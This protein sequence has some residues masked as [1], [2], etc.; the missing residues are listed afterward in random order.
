M[1][2]KSAP[3]L[4]MK[5]FEVEVHPAP[6]ELLVRSSPKSTTATPIAGIPTTIQRSKMWRVVSETIGA[7]DEEEEE[8]DAAA[9]DEEDD[10]AAATTLEAFFADRVVT[11][12]L[13]LGTE[14]TR[15]LQL[16][17]RELVLPI[18]ISC[19]CFQS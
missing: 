10:E 3:V 16:R 8:E 11:G 15:P 7:L 18:P 14:R 6:N 12:I 19:V 4:A 17:D 13:V 1:A 5:T 2:P 9:A